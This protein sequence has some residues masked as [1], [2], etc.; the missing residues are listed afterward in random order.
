MAMFLLSMAGSASAATTGQS[1]SLSVSGII[2][3]PGMQVYDQSG[4]RLLIAQILQ[5]TIA[6]TTATFSYSLHSVVAGDKV[7]GS[8]HF[9]IDGKSTAGD[10]I[11]VVSTTPLSGAAAGLCFPTLTV[12][13]CPAG[14][15]GVIPSLFSGSSTT[16]LKVDGK[17]QVLKPSMVF[18]SA[19]LNPFGN[20]IVLSST[21]GSIFAAF[22]YSA[23]TIDWTG[24]QLGGQF[25][26]PST[27]GSTPVTGQFVLASSST[28]NLVAGV[29]EDTG[30]MTFTSM[31]PS[32][33]DASG[34]Y[35]GTTTIPTAGSFD[36]S[37]S[38]PFPLLNISICTAT[39]ANSVGHFS[40]RNNNL[41]IQGVYQT[42]WSIPSLLFAS[43]VTGTASSS[44]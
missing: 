38:L 43:T 10:T 14:T 11:S 23:A 28:E 42:E 27:L 15:T 44:H 4:G 39:G 20:P 17:T 41:N 37:S 30:T 33:L 18:E 2:Q 12:G 7:V 16:V 5:Y 40:M 21:D 26:A 9:E 6:P 36:C 13:P 31:S 3:S 25:V 29:E 8:A 1:L 34:P 32:S 35:S 19:Y 22:T 24:V